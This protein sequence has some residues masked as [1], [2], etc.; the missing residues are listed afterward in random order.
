MKRMHK[1]VSDITAQISSELSGCYIEHE[2]QSIIY[3][4]FEHLLNYTKIDIHINSNK[5]I[6]VSIE[7]KIFE[8]INDLKNNKPVQ[9]IIGKTEFYG[10]ILKVSPD[11]LIPRQETEELVNWVVKEN[12]EEKIRIL[13]IGTGSGCIAVSL[14]KYLHDSVVVEAQ[15]KS[16]KAVKLAEYN[17]R[18]NKVKVKFYEYDILKHETNQIST[19]Y[20]IIVCNPPYIRDHEKS[21]LPANVMNYEPHEA[22]FVPDDDPMVFYRAIAKFGLRNLNGRGKLYFEINEY[23]ADQVAEELLK[24]RYRNIE[25]RKDINGKDRMVKAYKD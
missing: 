11:V 25:V 16:K 14:A 2:I 9:Y 3:L 23:L 12:T 19:G 15:D 5:T 17:A 21:A 1:T 22:L 7:K 13:D 8:I 24:Y 10:L 6:S 4:L 18:L 20:D